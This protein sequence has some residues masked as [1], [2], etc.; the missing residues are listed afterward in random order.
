MVIRRFSLYGFLKNQQYYDPFL[1]LAYIQMG[2]SFTLI[3]ILIAFRE[4]VINI[5][6]IPTGVIAD[7]F[8]RRKSMIYSFISYIISFATM[9]IVGILSSEGNMPIGLVF[10]LLMG[11]MVFFGMGDAFRTG[12]HKAMIFTWLRIQN[13]TSE[14]TKVYGFTRSWSKIGSAVSVII[15]CLLVY[16]SK[17]YMYI[18][19]FSIIPY[20]LNII[21]FIGYPKEVDGDKKNKTSISDVVRHIKEALVVSVKEKQLRRILTESMGF[22]GFFKVAK[23]Y[24]Q[25]ILE[26]AS[27]PLAAVLF[28]G[29][30][31]TSEQGS[32]LLIGPVYLLLYILSAFSSRKA[33]VLVKKIGEEEHA[34]C[35]LWGMLFL[36][37]LAMIPSLYFNNT[38]VVIACFVILYIL[39]N[40][41]R[42]VLM[43]RIDSHSDENKGATILSIESQAKSVSTMIIAPVIGFLV[44][45]VRKHEVGVGDFWPM[46][47]IGSIIALAFFVTGMRSAKKA[48]FK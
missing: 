32:V 22:E 40:L 23:D 2:L 10:V 39:Q 26:T 46:A 30:A 44:D 34:S 4:I 21:N 48:S 31:M 45:L 37:L 20:I 1:I 7:L 18:F 47:I 12:T 5:A 33:H 29:V 14:R 16:F 9:G 41:W 43:S 24:L 25:P 27:I 19:F 17:N 13:R 3:G 8:G 38:W 6:E 28:A 11:A 15:A 36:V 42:P 35:L